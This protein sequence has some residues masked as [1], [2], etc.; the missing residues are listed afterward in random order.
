[1]GSK[2]K[3]LKPRILILVE[4][5]E[6]EVKYF[7]AFKKSDKFKRNLDA[8]NIDIYKPKDHSPKGIATEAKHKIKFA[9]NEK[10][11]YQE[12]WLVLDRDKHSKIA[13]TFNEV[14]TH[15]NNKKIKIHIAFSNIC[16]EY[17]ILLHFDQTSRP[18]NRCDENK[19][20]EPNVIAYIK[21]N[22]E[23]NYNK[24][25]YNFL[26]LIETKLETA[27]KNAIW[28]EKRNETEL[29]KS[30]KHEINPYTDVHYLI[31]KIKKGFPREHT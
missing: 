9:N 16:F 18:F 13:E 5:I 4:G 27:I 7:N 19:N 3:Q 23:P 28:L 15:N 25:T 10:Y 31:D 30:P 6:T 2:V 29:I 12:F 22:H 26:Q 1:M 20:H 11:P 14:L 21:K 8:V 17:W 24:S